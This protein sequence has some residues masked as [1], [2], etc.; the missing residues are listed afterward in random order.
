MPIGPDGSLDRDSRGQPPERQLD[1]RGDQMRRVE[2]R[3]RMS[4]DQDGGERSLWGRGALKNR[5]A[6]SATGTPRGSVAIVGAAMLAVLMTASSTHVA[7]QCGH[8]GL[9]DRLDGLSQ[10]AKASWLVRAQ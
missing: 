5:S 6:G 9:S 7:R 2:V 10:D 8:V 3:L 4:G 1:S